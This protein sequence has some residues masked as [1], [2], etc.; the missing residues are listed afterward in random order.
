M[1]DTQNTCCGSATESADK[2]VDHKEETP[3]CCGS[4]TE[5]TDLER[6]ENAAESAGESSCCGS[7]RHKMR[8]PEQQKALLTRL[9]HAYVML[10]I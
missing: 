4:V 7:G 1:A 6:A 3:C 10:G 2:A 8:T 5:P 9:K